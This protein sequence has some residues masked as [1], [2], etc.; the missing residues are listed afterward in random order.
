M[1]GLASCFLGFQLFIKTQILSYAFDGVTYVIAKHFIN[2]INKIFFLSQ[3]LSMYLGSYA[4]LGS[5]VFFFCLPPL[6]LSSPPLASTSSNVEGLFHVYVF[7]TIAV[8][9][10]CNWFTQAKKNPFRMTSLLAYI[11]NPG[12]ISRFRKARK[13]SSN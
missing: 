3:N 11:A 7:N 6:P 10:L 4:I 1:D 9:S 8:C 5:Y 2:N 13:T 12:Y